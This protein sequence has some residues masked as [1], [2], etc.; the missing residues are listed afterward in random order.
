MKIKRLLSILL[1]VLLVIPSFAFASSSE[2]FDETMYLEKAREVLKNR[3]LTVDDMA[4]RD[5]RFN[6]NKPEYDPEDEVRLIVEVSGRPVRNISSISS[7][8]DIQALKTTQQAVM[9]EIKAVDEQVEFRH[10]FFQG[11][12]GFSISTKYKNL[13]EIKKI[14]GV[15]NVHIANKYVRDMSTSKELVNLTKTWNE[16]GYKGEGMLVAVIDTGIDWT[17]KDFTL[18]D[19]SSAKYPTKES[20]QDKLW[21]TEVPDTWYSEKVPTGYDWADNDTDVIPNLS[22]PLAS[23]HGVHVAG[24]V[25]ANGDILGVAPEA[26]LL[27]EKV[28]SDDDEY[29]YADDIVAGI[30]HAINMDADVINMSLGAVAGFVNPEDPEQ[31]A[32]SLAVDNGIIVAVSAG[33]SAYNTAAIYN[34]YASNPDIGV[35]GSPGVGL[36]TIQVASFENDI[37]TGPV[38]EYG[39]GKTALYAQA[40][41]HNP[42][43]VFN[44][45][46]IEYVYCGL[47]GEDAD[48]EGKDLSGKIALIQRGAYNFTDKIMNAQNHGAAGVIVFNHESGG[49][50]LVNMMYPEEG[51]IPAVFIGNTVGNE[52]LQLDNKVVK[53]G[54]NIGTGINPHKGE[55]SDFTSWGLTPDL[56]F[57]PEITAP[58]GDIWSTVNGDKYESM[59]GTSMA[60]PHVAGGSALVSQAL[61]ERGYAKNRDLVELAKILMMNT[62]KPIVDPNSEADTYY[63]PRRQGAGLM[64]IDEALETPAYVVG[65]DGKA[66]VSL[67]E[68]DDVTNFTLTLTTLDDVTVS[69]SVYYAVYANVL[70]DLTFT[71]EYG[72]EYLSIEAVPVDGALLSLNGT[73]INDTVGEAVYLEKDSMLNLN[74]TL[75][76]SGADLPTERF[77]E[78]FIEFRPTDENHHLPT[79]SVPY[80]GFYGDWDEPNNID[81]PMWDAETYL[82]ITGL[83]DNWNLYTL[84][85]DLE[86]I[87]DPNNVA[88]SPNGDFYYDGALP[89]FTLLRNAKEFKVYVEDESGNVVKEV[90]DNLT[91]E[92]ADGIKELEEG[93][94]K[95]VFESSMYWLDFMFEWDAT[96]NSGSL[97]PDGQ[98]NIVLESKIDFDG[99]I[100]QELVLPVKVDTEYP[101]FEGDIT[102]TQTAEGYTID[103]NVVDKVSGINAYVVFINGDVNNPI[104]T[105]QSSVTVD[106]EPTSVAIIAEDFAGNAELRWTGDPVIVD[107]SI[108]DTVTVDGNYVSYERP[109][110]LIAQTIRPVN[111]TVTVEDPSGEIVDTLTTKMTS[112]FNETWTPDQYA[113]SGTYKAVFT[114]E[115]IIDGSTATVE[116]QFEVYNYASIVKEVK[117]LDINGIEIETASRNTTVQVETTVENLGPNTI[118]PTI[119]VKVTDSYG[120]VINIG[121]INVDN[122]ESGGIQK[123]TTGFTIPSNS[124]V[125]T[126][127]AEV[128]VWDNWSD[129]N[130]LS[131]SG[132]M[133]FIVE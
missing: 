111:W 89:V 91:W 88:I 107:A 20:I 46:E 42:V 31:K 33:N 61:Q 32:I 37:I 56:E 26:Q 92:N 125:G 64:Q 119:I 47:G 128:Y 4:K 110:Q 25:A 123:V 133:Q 60:A 90:F 126:Y 27:A 9:N 67:K 76:L 49:N 114:V 78:G 43:E 100:T 85:A 74:F 45:Q 130:A 21:S 118:S 75:D 16:L 52:L 116:Q 66:A 54:G 102:V 124:P 13:E 68:I 81:L 93:L 73:N 87:V 12:N 50:D 72:Y 122:L 98:Y 24:T 94:R 17:H 83:Y 86:G 2:E 51:T 8:R 106:V 99:A 96:D 109:A 105:T 112:F 117:L 71:D 38:L 129:M 63:S 11:I 19:P 58:G 35:V 97:V 104:V 57:K 62:A 59:S 80:V 34:P 79:L 108:F 55:M 5:I 39:N 3:A 69:N 36:D 18:T 1:A 101:T 127:K 14:P 115:D 22:H 77:V 15:T 29:A 53:F 28:F 65:E 132:S 70:T 44:G 120:R 113:Q 41:N 23:P 84:G 7:E 121:S 40:G 95:N 30:I 82:G 48:F 103:W 131:Q 10:Q 6:D